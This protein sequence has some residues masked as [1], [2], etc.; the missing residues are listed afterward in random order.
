MFEKK[1]NKWLKR[2]LLPE[3]AG[4]VVA[5]CAATLFNL[6]CN[7]KVIVA[8]AATVGEAIGFYS[9]MFVSDLLTENKKRK[10]KNV[11]FNF[12]NIFKIFLSLLIEFGPAG[13]IDGIFLRPFF[14][15]LFPLVFK[16]FTFGIFIGKIVGD[17]MFYLIVML[18]NEYNQL[19]NKN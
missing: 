9:T 13:I 3:I 2:Y 12:K 5:V 1:V 10:L 8:Y 4:T 17:I 18:S 16:S 19:K 11:K 15:Y 14:M 7:N 6:F